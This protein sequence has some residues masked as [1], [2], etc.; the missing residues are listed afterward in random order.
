MK[1]LLLTLLVVGTLNS[2]KKDELKDVI[3]TPSE[4]P[5][6]LALNPSITDTTAILFGEV[7]FTDGDDST[8]RGLCWSESPNPTTNDNFHVD[9]STG[10]GTYSFN[11][12][13]QIKPN[14]TY[15]FRAFAQNSVG[16]V[17][18]EQEK[19]FFLKGPAFF[20]SSGCL[21]CDKLA[22]G[23]KFELEG[24]EYTVAD[25]E[26]LDKALANGEDL[27]KFCTSKV[28]DL[29]RIF[30]GA[31]SFNQ[32]ISNWDVSNV[33]DMTSVFNNAHAFNQDI[34]NWNV[35][36]VTNMSTMF[37]GALAFNQN[38]GNWDVSSVINM[39]GMFGSASAFNQDIGNWNVSNVTNM[40]TM[41]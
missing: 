18:S 14:T 26:M 2:C 10:L 41:F 13:N 21:E 24:T 1:S 39:R 12:F 28:D 30:L 32:N 4:L 40:S 7:T 33:T 36:N 35:S 16:K 37:F 29:S 11:V 9:D 34:G 8:I 5:T 23:D 31:N 27:T 38:I 22:V 17:Y 3:N 25:R 19:S 6:V 20:N 15:Y